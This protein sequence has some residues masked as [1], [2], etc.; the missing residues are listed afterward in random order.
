MELLKELAQAWG[1]SGREK[2]IREIVKREVSPYADELFTD[3][4]G[5]LIALKKGAGTGKKIM[6]AAHMDEIGLQ[7]KKI[8]ADGRIVAMR[9]GWIGKSSIYHDKV[10]FQNGVVGVVGC[11]G[12]IEEAPDDVG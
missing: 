7:V 2:I 11:V 4:M 5:N 3:A 1:V 8:E 12:P 6:L 10:R 9:V